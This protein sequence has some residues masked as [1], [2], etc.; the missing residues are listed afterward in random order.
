MTANRE[1]PV[2]EA[3]RAHRAMAILRLLDGE[4][5]G[6]ANNELLA[7]ILGVLGLRTSCGELRELL[8]FLEREGAVE[9]TDRETLTV[10][11]LRRHGQEL[12]Q[13]LVAGEGIERP[14]ADCPY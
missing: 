12:A 14:A 2:R 1:N 13:G 4:L 5:G 9:L 3:M 6:F 8:S 10:I 11:R 7:T